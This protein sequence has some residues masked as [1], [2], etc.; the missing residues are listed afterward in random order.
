MGTTDI[1]AQFETFLDRQYN[2]TTADRRFYPFTEVNP[3]L[4]W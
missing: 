4:P 1:N 2:M 3:Y